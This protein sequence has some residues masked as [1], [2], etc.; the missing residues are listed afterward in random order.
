M[1]K[2]FKIEKEE[3]LRINRMVRRDIDIEFQFPKLRH[4]VHKNKKQYNR[5]EKKRIEEY[6]VD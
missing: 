1:A 4:S 3:L 2:T 6:L 5:Q